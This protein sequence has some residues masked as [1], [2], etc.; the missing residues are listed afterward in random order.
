MMMMM[1]KDYSG[2]GDD[3]SVEDDSDYDGDP[4]FSDHYGSEYNF[5]KN[6]RHCN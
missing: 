3:D 1:M 5:S 4:D 6:G 2:V